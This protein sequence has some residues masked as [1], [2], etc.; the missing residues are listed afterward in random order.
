MTKATL[1]TQAEILS[2][3]EY[4]K[5]D[6]TIEDIPDFVIDM[7]ALDVEML[8]GKAHALPLVYT[9]VIDLDDVR[10]RGYLWA[11]HVC[12]V[13]ESLS[14]RG[15]IEQ[16]S[17]DVA[18]SKIGNVTTQ[19]QRWQP[20][21]FFAKGMAQGFFE[22]LPHLTYQMKAMQLV[23]AWKSWTFKQT[24]PGEVPW[25]TVVGNLDERS[26][27]QY[28]PVMSTLDTIS[29]VEELQYVIPHA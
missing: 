19:F 1:T 16:S 22:L 2:L 21:F 28:L 13:L 14:M 27:V 3:L 7:A 23:R 29:I 17:G 18:E 8:L 9:S 26:N 4:A 10:G 11:S 6:Y 5:L 15:Q 12:L 24:Y 20:M 25:G